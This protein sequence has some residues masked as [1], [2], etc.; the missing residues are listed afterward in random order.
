M[1]GKPFPKGTKVFTES[2]TGKKTFYTITNSFF[3]YIGNCWMYEFE[4]SS[5]RIP[6]YYLEIAK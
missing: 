1:I 6:H 4:E 3:H 2:T 5:S